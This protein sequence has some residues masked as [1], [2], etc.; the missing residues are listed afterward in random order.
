MEARTSMVLG[1][2]PENVPSAPLLPGLRPARMKP[3][4]NRV[5][6]GGGYGSHE[7]NLDANLPPL[8]QGHRQTRTHGFV[9]MP[10]VRLELTRRKQS[11]RTGKT[12]RNHGIPRREWPLAHVP[13]KIPLPLIF[14]VALPGV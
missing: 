7:K 13:S 3:G 12:A 11:F 5:R 14:L 9:E 6:S 1:N 4:Y 2:H 10:A 8:R